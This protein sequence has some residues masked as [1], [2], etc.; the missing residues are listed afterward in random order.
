MGKRSVPNICRVGSLVGLTVEVDEENSYKFEYVR[1]KIECRNSDKILD[2][3]EGALGGYL[4]D[5]GFQKEVIQ[6]G[7]TNP[8]GNQWIRK[9]DTSVQK[10]DK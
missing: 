6:R 9:D 10:D 5:F 3:V 4:Y 7:V 8:A 2:V 1:A